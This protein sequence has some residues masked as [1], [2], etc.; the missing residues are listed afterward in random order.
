MTT[1]AASPLAPTPWNEEARLRE[2][3]AYPYDDDGP[4]GTLNR[5]CGLAQGLFN[6]PTALVT[7]V[8]RDEQSFIA[9]CGVDIDG[10]PRK[11]AFCSWTI[12]DDEVLVVRDAL[13]DPRF[14]DNPLVTDGIRIRFYA[15]APLAVTAGARLGALCLID[16]RPRD[17]SDADAERLRALAAIAVNELGRRRSLIDLKRREDQLAQTARLAKVGSWVV[18]RAADEVTWSDETRGILEVEQEV[19]PSLDFMRDVIDP[20]TGEQVWAAAADRLRQG[21]PFDGEFQIQTAKG[22]SKWLRCVAEGEIADGA[23]QRISGSIQDITRERARNAQIERLAFHDTL[24]GLPNRALFLRRLAAAGTGQSQD[25]PRGGV[26][27][28]GVDCLKDVNGALGHDAGDAVLRAVAGRLLRAYGPDDT[29]AR[30]GGDEFAVLA[31]RARSCEDLLAPT[32]LLLEQLRHPVRVGATSISITASAGVAL[33]VDGDADLSQ[34]LKAADIALRRAKDGGRDR[35]AAFTPQMRQEIEGHVALL[36]EVSDAAPADEFVLHYQ[37]LADLRQP[38]RIAG[39]E[40]LMRWRHPSRGLL[41]PAAFA[42][43]LDDPQCAVVLGHAALEAAIGQMRGWLDDGVEFGRVAVNL[44]APQFRTGDLVDTVLGKLRRWG[45][46]AT[47]LALEVTENVPIGWGSDAVTDAMR[48]LREAGIQIA[49][50]DF[51]TGYASLAH[52][53]RLPIDRLKIDKSFVRSGQDDAI[54]RAIASIGASLGLQVVAEGIEAAHEAETL[55]A[56]GCHLGQGYHFGKPMT[57]G[58][59]AAFLE[60]FRS[61]AQTASRP[62][63]HGAPAE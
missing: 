57:A 5:L 37:P 50:D 36:R 19:A 20:D 59:V 53:R 27:V 11:D 45:V 4:E 41:P 8:G 16:T 43:A 44:S 30:L 28:L 33:G 32:R 24:T 34:L 52:L 22:R 54:L 62:G 42:V 39:F 56:M 60:A 61:R 58:E 1:R 21:L 46:P 29:V 10:T 55:R 47:R 38:G 48:A 9:R 7:L 12:L 14:R 31:P 13:A 63:V 40:A 2:V 25:R 51:G 6:V 35:I 49:L 3:L 26:V 18:D 15:G 17:F 23:A